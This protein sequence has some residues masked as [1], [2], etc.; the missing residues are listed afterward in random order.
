MVISMPCGALGALCIIELYL[1]TKIEAF[2][3]ELPSCESGALLED[4]DAEAECPAVFPQARHDIAWA[5][6][7]ESQ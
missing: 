4:D 5:A 6:T 2:E 3:R 7:S 1:V